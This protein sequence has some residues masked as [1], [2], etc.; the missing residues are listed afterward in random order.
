MDLQVKMTELAKSLSKL[1]TD[2]KV[3]AAAIRLS[4]FNADNASKLMNKTLAEVRTQQ[5]TALTA[6]VAVLVPHGETPAGIGIPTKDFIDKSSAGLIPSGILPVSRYGSFNYLPVGVGGSYESGTSI[7]GYGYVAI[8]TMMEPDGTLTYLR[9]ATDGSTQGAYYSYLPNAR[10]ANINNVV[11]SNRKYRPPF[12]PADMDVYRILRGNKDVLL[13]EAIKTDGSGAR[14]LF[15]AY[16]NNTLNDALHTGNLIP[17]SNYNPILSTDHL[18]WEPVL[19]GNTIYLIM[20]LKGIFQ[21]STN[22]KCDITVWKLSGAELLAGT[23]AKIAPLKGWTT[24]GVRKTFTNVD[25]I[26]L[27]D[28]LSSTDTAPDTMFTFPANMVP[29]NQWFAGYGNGAMTLTHVDK[30]TGKLRITV[31]GSARI[32]PISSQSATTSLMWSTEVDPVAMSAELD[33]EFLG[34]ASFAVSNNAITPSN[35]AYCNPNLRFLSTGEMI[36]GGR[37]ITITEDGYAFVVYMANVTE[38]THAVYRAKLNNLESVYKFNPG[39]VTE[40]AFSK[41]NTGAVMPSPIGNGYRAVSLFPNGY[42]RTVSKGLGNWQPV[43]AQ[44]RTANEDPTFMY[45]SV[46]GAPMPGYSPKSDRKASNVIG[47]NYSTLTIGELDI[48]RKLVSLRTTQFWTGT[49]TQPL[50]VNEKQVASGT[51]SLTPGIL[52]TAAKA[53]YEGAGYPGTAKDIKAHLIIPKD[54]TAPPIMMIWAIQPDFTQCFACY[55]VNVDVREGTVKTLTLVRLAGKYAGEIVT[56]SVFGTADALLLHGAVYC[57]YAEG[58]AIT[59]SGN[60]RW[61]KAGGK[62]VNSVKMFVNTDGTIEGFERP[63]YTPEYSV[64]HFFAFPD[65]GPGRLGNVVTESDFYTKL[66]F[67]P[68]GTTKANFV[69]PPVYTRDQV[70]IIMSQQVATGWS[71]FFTE[72]TPLFMSGSAYSVPVQTIDLTKLTPDP[73]NKKF[74]VYVQLKQGIPSY[75]VQETETNESET[76]MYIGYIRTGVTSVEQLVI[77]KVDRIGTFRISTSA[78]GS[79]IP[80]SAGHPALAA[81]MSWS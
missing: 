21:V 12:I 15:I 32:L 11:L 26:Q 31:Y 20:A 18:S 23:L 29:G 58:W 52:E 53:M 44:Y 42:I 45:N 51:M 79:A 13:G 7:G 61:T 81:K 78:T 59:A 66:Y 19:V 43:M 22:N 3:A 38:Q 56:S 75:L 70:V 73:S 77:D 4:A 54:P 67:Q 71:V 27:A 64:T 50:T 68:F 9:N 41:V 10:L 39:V 6:H 24:K 62:S 48:N 25:T 72:A 65:L 69:N 30:A 57:K 16:C 40:G 47:G 37:N 46:T 49:I 36:Y 74:Y 17:I 76:T 8:A 14:Q 80:V 28:I 1:M 63:E 60:G 2:I 35:L 55:T 33:K 34:G 5:D